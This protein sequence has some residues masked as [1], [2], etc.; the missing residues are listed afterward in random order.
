VIDEC[1]DGE[2]TRGVPVGGGDRGDPEFDQDGSGGCWLTDNVDGNSDVDN[3]T[4]TLISPQIDATNSGAT[5]SYA[6]WYSNCGGPGSG[7]EVFTVDVSDDDG[8]TWVNLEVVGPDDEESCGEW[9]E[10]TYRI[11]DYVQNTDAFRIRFIAADDNGSQTR[12]EAG[13][14]AIVVQATECIEDPGIPGDINNDGLVNGT[15]LGLFLAMWGNLGGPADFNGDGEVT[16]AD[17]GILIANWT[18]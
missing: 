5:I 11:G 7:E 4:T 2:W 9:F 3:G 16:G 13:I 15:D 1:G 12:V 8:E 14:D 10:V 18:G 6:R 17:L